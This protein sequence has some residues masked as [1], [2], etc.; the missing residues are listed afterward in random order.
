LSPFNKPRGHTYDKISIVTIREIIEGGKRLEI[1]MSL[2]V[3]KPS[4][5]QIPDKWT[6]YRGGA[7]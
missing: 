3:L 6:D 4:R 2:K 5:P 7:R 1:P